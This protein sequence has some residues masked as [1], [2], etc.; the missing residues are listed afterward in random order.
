MRGSMRTHP[1]KICLTCGAQ[2]PRTAPSANRKYCS[3][4]CA[5]ENR[6]TRWTEDEFRKAVAASGTIA[7]TARRL[8]M[9]QNRP[10][11]T[12]YIKR[13]GIDTSH[14]RG[15]GHVSD[16]VRFWRKVDRTLGCWLWDGY[17]NHD[18]YGRFK[19]QGG[20]NVMAH[21]FAYEAEVGKVPT[22]LELDHTCNVR[23]CVNPA[24]LEAVTHLE[25]V[26][27]AIERAA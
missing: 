12:K 22:G 20:R 13:L 25:N 26:R 27:R 4:T 1:S 24:H 21:I 15:F 2:L 18:G 11:V 3:T 14:F 5:T 7:E 23:H 10:T 9:P 8:G 16:E 17:T 19:V 6:S